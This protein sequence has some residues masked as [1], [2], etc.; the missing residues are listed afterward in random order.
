[1]TTSRASTAD[2]EVV[3]VD[4]RDKV[5]GV[6]P[7]FEV[8]RRGQLHRAVSVVLFDD[9]GRLLLQRRAA[10]KYH[11]AGLWSNTCCGHPRPGESVGDAARRRLMDEMG[12]EGCGLTRVTEF[13]YFAELDGGLVEYELDHVLIGRWNGP[14]NPDPGEVAETRWIDRDLL[15]EELVQDPDRYTAWIGRVVGHACRHEGM[16]GVLRVDAARRYG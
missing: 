6:G 15:F 2:D 5:V 13:L 11:S 9:Q 7:K 12:I 14:T 3:L 4:R 16:V 1:M 8:H 10:A